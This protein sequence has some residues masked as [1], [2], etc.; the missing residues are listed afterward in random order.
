M[1]RTG[2]RGRF[3]Q[4]GVGFKADLPRLRK[5]QSQRLR[6]IFILEIFLGFLTFT[7][8]PDDRAY[9]QHGNPIMAAPQLTQYVQGQGV[10]SGDQANTFEQTCDNVSQ[11]RAL[12]GT[13]GMQIYTR[14]YSSPNDGGQGPFYWNATSTASDDGQNTI[15]PTGAGSGAWN[16]LR[17]SPCFS[18]R[19]N[20]AISNVTGNAAAF[21]IPYNLVDFN[22]GCSLASG[23][24]T[25]LVAGVY[26]FT[27]SVQLTGG[28]N[29][30]TEAV[31][32]LLPTSSLSLYG[33]A[34]GTYSNGSGGIS[35]Q[36]A[37]AS[38]IFNLNANDTVVAQ[39]S[40]FGL[41][42]NTLGITNSPVYNY[43]CGDLIR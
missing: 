5:L 15:V 20:T 10:I 21:T 6:F 17:G 3:Y 18:Y 11:M 37:S 4:A 26:R 12:V 30:I 27:A 34:S 7:V 40:A 23:I 24:F 14:G 31:L 1:I 36:I 43:F 9:L 13:T 42:G 19:L 29:N 16:R 38:A 22:F 39:V 32:Q 35:A 41:S 2:L 28:S 33:S 8:S 25:A